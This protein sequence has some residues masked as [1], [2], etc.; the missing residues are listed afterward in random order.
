MNKPALQST[1]H[2]SMLLTHFLHCDIRFDSNLCVVFQGFHRSTIKNF[3]LS[4]DKSLGG[5]SFL[6]IWHDNSGKGKYKSWYLNQ[7]QVTNLQ[8]GEK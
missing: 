8:T 3:I 1:H 6:R 5:L 7:I 2:D 4:V